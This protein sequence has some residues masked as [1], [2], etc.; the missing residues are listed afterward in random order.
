MMLISTLHNLN[1]TLGFA[2]LGLS[3]SKL[4]LYFFGG[5]LALYFSYKVL[6]GEF[7]YFLRIENKP[8]KYIVS[9]LERILGKIVCDF[10]GC[11]HMR[12][13]GELGGLAHLATVI[14]SQIFPFIALFFFD[15]AKE[16][17]SIAA[18]FLLS[19]TVIWVGLYLVFLASIDFAYIDTFFSPIVSSKYFCNHFSSMIVDKK[20]Q[21][22][23]FWIFHTNLSQYD[24]IKGEIKSWVDDNIDVWMEQRPA[25]FDETLLPD[26]FL[27]ER[28]FN[29]LGGEKRRRSTDFK[30]SFSR[31]RY[32]RDR[33]A[34]R[35]HPEYQ[36]K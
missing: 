13:P 35:V 21:E 16:T 1:R 29:S 17:K 31:D 4:F 23:A 30:L 11:I 2:M 8:I 3:D 25:W 12:I 6:R 18:H 26:E 20:S 5:E 36:I 15:G 34:R 9:F 27:P 14:Y 28:V 7:I 19:T 32:L 10:S 22:W 24:P 33:V